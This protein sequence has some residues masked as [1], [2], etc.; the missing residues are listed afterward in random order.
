MYR[1]LLKKCQQTSLHFATL[2]RKEQIVKILLEREANI[3]VLNK[4]FF[5]SI[6]KN[7]NEIIFDFFLNFFDFLFF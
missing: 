7:K 2:N 3:E 4:I 6:M 5:I 1:V